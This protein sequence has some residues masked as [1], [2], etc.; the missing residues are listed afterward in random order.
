MLASMMANTTLEDAELP[1]KRVAVSR[2]YRAEAEARGAATKGLYHVHEFTKVEMFAWTL[3]TKAVQNE[4]FDEI[5]S[6][7]KTILGSLGLH[8]Q[9]LEMPSTDL[10]A[11]ASRKKDI[12]AFFPSRRPL[13]DGFKSVSTCRDYQMRRLATRVDLRSQGGKMMFPYTV[14]GTAMAIPRVL[15]AILENG[16]DERRM[17]VKVPDR[18][19]DA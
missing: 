2:C 7:Q 18:M 11:S 16:W 9:V 17:E 3:P 6:I 13:D 14:N 4:I 15:A 1:V 10:G 19:A 8:Y 5:L 12:E